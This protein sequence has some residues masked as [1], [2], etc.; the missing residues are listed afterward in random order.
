MRKRRACKENIAKA[1]L[2][3]LNSVLTKDVVG[4]GLFLLDIVDTIG[5]CLRERAETRQKEY[6][7]IYKGSINNFSN[8]CPKRELKRNNL[9][10]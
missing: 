5:S 10:Y 8:M 4:T 2:S 1:S 7:G 6:L 9:G 3:G